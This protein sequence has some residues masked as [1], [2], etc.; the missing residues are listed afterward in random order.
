VPPVGQQLVQ[1]AWVAPSE[2]LAR[3]AGHSRMG[4]IS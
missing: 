2:T 3:R 1:V 4:E